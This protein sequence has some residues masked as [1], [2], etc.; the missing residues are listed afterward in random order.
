MNSVVNAN[1]D[2]LD[3]CTYDIE[4]CFNALWTHEC[5]NDIY[6]AGMTNDKLPLLYKMNMNAKVAIKMSQVI[7]DRTNIKNIIMHGFVWGSL[8]CTSKMDKLPKRSYAK[9]STSIQVQGGSGIASI[10]YGL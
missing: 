6:E 1:K 8:S 4:K 9:Q 5:I 2:P 7:P 10:R 3:I